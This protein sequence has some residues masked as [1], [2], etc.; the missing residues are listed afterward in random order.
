M[1]TFKRPIY[2]SNSHQSWTGVASEAVDFL[3]PL[4]PFLPNLALVGNVSGRRGSDHFFSR[5]LFTTHPIRCSDSGGYSDEYVQELDEHDRET[6]IALRVRRRSF[7]KPKPP[8]NAVRASQSRR[9]TFLPRTTTTGTIHVAD[10]RAGA[11]ETHGLATELHYNLHH[12]V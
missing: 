9:S 11:G 12:S 5:L 7:C 6:I 2:R 4:M 1:L 8:P 3:V 10:R